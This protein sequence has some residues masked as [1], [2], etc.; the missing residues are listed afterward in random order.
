M[1]LCEEYDRIPL[2]HMLGLP[3]E[4]V[5]RRCEALADSVSG[6][7]AKVLETR[8]MIGGGAAPG[9]TVQSFALSLACDGMNAT[10]L[11]RRLRQQATPIVARVEADRVLLDL[12]TVDAADDSYLAKTLA[13]L[14]R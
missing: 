13:T 1:Y 6:L 9:K 10:E 3:A 8:S 2:L 7:S 12:R 4:D 5:R 14:V 11:A